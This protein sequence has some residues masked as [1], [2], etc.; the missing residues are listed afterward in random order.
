MIGDLKP[1]ADYKDSG[2][3]WLG[4]VPAHWRVVRNGSLFGQ[5]SQTGYAELPILEVSLKTG[6][7][8]RSFGGAKRKQVMSD[9][10][11][12]KRAVK[13]DLAYNTMRM[14]Q[15]A[16]GICPVDGLV[17]PA[18]VVAR[19]YPEVVP[20]YFAALFRTGD[21]MAEIDAASRGI[22]KDRNRLYWDQFKQMQSPCPP[23]DE[24]A[25][26]VRFLAWA[27]GRLERAIRAKR[28]VIALLTEQKLVIVRRMVT[29]GLD[30]SVPLKASKIDWLGDI[31]AHWTVWRVSRFARVGNGSTPSRAQP[32]YWDRGTYPWLNSSQVNR[33]Y[34]DHADQFVTPTALRECHLPRVPAG[35][36]LVA[37]TGQGKTRG[38]SAKLGIEATI[39]QHL[40]Y[41]TPRLPVVSAD[42]LHLALSA[43]YPQLRAISDDSGSTK[44][45]LT[46]EDLKRFK[47]ALPP[48]DEQ[49]ALVERV[50]IEASALIEAS[51]RLEREIDFLHEYRTRL[52]ADVV[53]GKL[54][55]REAVTRLPA[56]V[57]VDLDT[58]EAD[59]AD[60]PELIDEEAA[61]A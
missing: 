6:V 44:G 43:A 60:D 1:Y 11:K 30:A 3:P 18:Y 14:W 49:A 17:S 33:G 59:A 31:P 27:N 26:I 24:Q 61:A 51:E 8:V 42:Y 15:G 38:M 52:V 22:V 21:Y 19:P 58:G 5:R 54:D 45:A 23:P 47:L 25:A 41:I 4:Q 13:G 57:S 9:F 28:K 35:S 37:I 55:V 12:Y 50:R 40:A 20:E 48:P 10:G 39:N 53:T 34:I 56:D 46:C 36:V 29:R 16:L 7:Q 32:R 2:L